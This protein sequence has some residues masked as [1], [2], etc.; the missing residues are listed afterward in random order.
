[1]GIYP[2]TKPVIVELPLQSPTTAVLFTDGLL[3]AGVRRG[4]S[5][6]VPAVVQALCEGPLCDAQSI[7]DRLL[8]EALQL[9]EK[10]PGDDITILALTAR[11]PQ[12]VSESAVDVRRLLLTFPLED[13]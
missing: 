2:G 10:R 11:S 6:D 1:V 7:V 8:A 12:I 4:L 5:M 9:D 3:D 13:G